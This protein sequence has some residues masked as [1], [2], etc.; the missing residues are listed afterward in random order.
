MHAKMWFEKLPRYQSLKAFKRCFTV[1]FEFKRI[2]KSIKWKKKAINVHKTET[3]C[4]IYQK[5]DKNFAS[6]VITYLV[7][8]R[9][10][11]CLRI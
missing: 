5:F 8:H 1:N 11:F 6:W 4:V 2:I 10:D 3:L 7:G 9:E